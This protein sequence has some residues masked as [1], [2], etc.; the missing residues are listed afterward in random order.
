M[1]LKREE[2]LF[3]EMVIFFIKIFDCEYCL[4]SISKEKDNNLIMVSWLEIGA[5]RYKFL[6]RTFKIKFSRKEK[7]IPAHPGN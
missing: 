4:L 3:G 7:K 2:I 1:N 6:Y 5:K